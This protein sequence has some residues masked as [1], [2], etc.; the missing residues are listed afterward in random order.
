MKA[1]PASVF[2]G[3]TGE[4][5][6]ARTSWALTLAAVMTGSAA[7]AQTAR[8]DLFPEPDVRQASTHWVNSAY[9]VDK[10][11]NQFWVCTARDSF[12][13]EQANNG[14]CTKLPTDI[15]RPSITESY[16]ARAVTGSTPQGPLLPVVWFIEPAI[17]DVQFCAIRHARACVRM[18]LAQ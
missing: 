14:E 15:G 8:Y 12:A 13:S 6:F 9:V 5:M 1:M 16:Q 3:R 10:K 18:R 7:N 4:V 2:A 11:A 17:S